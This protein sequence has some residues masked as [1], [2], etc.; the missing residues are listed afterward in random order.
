MSYDGKAVEAE[1]RELWKQQDTY[2]KAKARAQRPENKKLYFLDG[3]PYTSGHVHLGTAWNKSLKDLYIRYMRMRGYNIWDRA[4][5][6]MHGLPTERATEKALNIFG[7]DAIREYGVDKFVEKCKQTCLSN[8]DDMSKTF[9][10]MGVWMDFENAYRSVER[11][12]IEGVWWFIV[13]AWEQ[14]RLY[15]A[16]KT[17]TWDAVNAT[18]LAKHELDYKLVTDNTL[19]VRFPIVGRE[20]EYLVIWTTTPWTIPFNL[21]VMVNPKINYVKV[22][23][24][25]NDERQFWYIAEARLEAFLCGELKL[26]K[27]KGPEDGG[28]RVVETL[29]GEKLQGTAYVHPFFKLNPVYGELKARMPKVHTVVLSAQ[30]VTTDAGTGLVHCA[31]GCG[32]EDYVVG[33]ENGIEPFNT[34]DESGVVRN[35]EPLNGLRA[36]LD[37]AKFIQIIKENGGFVHQSTIEHEYPYGE[38]SQ[39][40]VIFRTTTQWFI[41]VEDIK[42]KM[43]AANSG[44]YWNPETAKNAFQSWLSNLRD[45]SISKQR[46]WG[47]PLPIWR[48]VDDPSDYIVIGTANQLCELAGLP[49]DSITDL[50]PPVLDKIDFKRVSPKD[51]KEHLYHRVP[52]ILDVWVDAGSSAWNCLRMPGDEA[53]ARTKPEDGWLPAVFILEGRDQIRGWFNLLHLESMICFG[54]PCFQN[55]FMHGFIRDSEGRKMSKSLGNY[56]LPSEVWDKYGVD[57][58]RYVLITAANGGE[59]MNYNPLDVETRFRNLGVM[60]NVATYLNVTANSNADVVTVLPMDKLLAAEDNNLGVEEKYILS[61]L[62]TMIRD[63]D[64]LFATYK[65][66]RVPTAIMDF[67]MEISHVYIQLIWEKKDTGSATEKRAVVSTLAECLLKAITMFAA[68]CPFVSEK[69]YQ[70]MRACTACGISTLC[71]EESVHLLPWPTCNESLIVPALEEDVGAAKDVIAAILSAREKAGLAVKQPS[72]DVRISCLPKY[73]PMIQRTTDLIKGRTNVKALSFE[74]PSALVTVTPNQKTIGKQFGRDR[75]RIVE[76]INSHAEEIAKQCAAPE[77]KADEHWSMTAEFADGSPSVVLNDTHIEVSHGVAKTWAPGVAGDF[78]VYVDTVR[79]EELELE[80]R[81]RELARKIQ[82]LRKKG[83]LQRTDRAALT[84]F[85]PDDAAQAK[86]L[87][88]LQENAKFIGERTQSTVTITPTPNPEAAMK[89]LPAEKVRVS[90]TEKL[91]KVAIA[92]V[93]LA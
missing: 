26:D 10:F 82:G 87:A 17:M 89:A 42:D 75:K 28:F 12:Y 83:N 54:K 84:I 55:V 6:D 13:K 50:H 20:H 77:R 22:E 38:R 69:I 61:R 25:H 5:Y 62:H 21:A 53:G 39:K 14:G 46:F 11:E 65:L 68:A 81:V 23:V 85:V 7:K 70:N 3:P 27:T 73:V 63:V 93:I 76:F 79:T 90:T 78:K 56:I 18:A 52:D 58:L 48:N 19:Y 88:A 33:K 47:T 74:P 91:G 35:L 9:Q 60:W 24:N 37:D 41:R 67:I 8:M 71:T 72:R 80:G 44:I 34:V 1:I 43:L 32:P 30:F 59:D 49:K 2:A 86:L 51:G 40:P 29:I 15:E 36:K 4:G 31:P 16:E 66:N 64:Q 57:T 92:L 45:N